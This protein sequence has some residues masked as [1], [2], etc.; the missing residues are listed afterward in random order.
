MIFISLLTELAVLKLINA[1]NRDGKCYIE[2]SV[3]TKLKLDIFI[4]LPA[5]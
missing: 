1:T 4:I 2:K 3:T 5:R